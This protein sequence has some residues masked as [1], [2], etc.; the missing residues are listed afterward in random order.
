MDDRR[1]ALAEEEVGQAVTRCG[2][3]GSGAF[4][5]LAITGSVAPASAAVGESLVWRFR[6]AYN[7][8][9]GMVQNVYADFQVPA[10]VT[11]TSTQS[12]RGPGCQ[13]LSGGSVHCNLD[14]MGVGGE[15]NVILGSN[16]TAAGELRL[17]GTVGSQDADPAPA[18]N[19][20]VLLANTPTQAVTPSILS[21]KL[22]RPKLKTML[23]KGKLLVYA[24]CS[25]ACTLKVTVKFKVK[26]R[27]KT[28]VMKVTKTVQL[29]AAKR[30]TLQLKPNKKVRAL[31]L[32]A[33]AKHK[34][35][36]VNLAGA[37]S[38]S[39]GA[40]ASAKLTFSSRR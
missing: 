40:K 14:V 33:L 27:G 25:Q 19:T 28:R 32:K 29:S 22:Q 21:L 6:V 7:G 16:V 39:S 3:G 12:D 26:T 37:A 10:G 9:Y 24:T 38:A 2:A 4:G 15:V 34:K 18:D 35:V 31:V 36:T 23:K 13:V 11:I 8:Y 20:V 1:A 30:T 5:D 17:T